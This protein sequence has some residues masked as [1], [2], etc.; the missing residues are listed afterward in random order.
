MA[1]TENT[2]GGRV[3]REAT[4]RVSIVL[5]D[6]CLPGDLIGLSG[7]TWVRADSSNN[8]PP[9]LVAGERCTA[10]G[11]TIM[12]YRTAIVGNFS[13]ASVGDQ[14]YAAGAS[15]TTGQYTATAPA[16]QYRVGKML[17]ATDAEV[18]LN[19]NAATPV[20]V[21]YKTVTGS[22]GA[23]TL[24]AESFTI[25]TESLTTAAGAV[26]TH[27]MTNSVV[28]A[29]DRV[30][31]TVDVGSSAGTPA[32]ASVTPS[33]GQI[34]FKIQNIHASAAFNNAIK[35]NAQVVH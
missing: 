34:V 32:L 6:T 1:F 24:A 26:Y 4:G 17:S 16:V 28:K 35:I 5:T 3:L 25:T 23:S 14:L 33:A 27:T 10:S 7:T 22:A 18:D 12:A 19:L 15:S 29:T 30:L 31:A 21:D 11:G 2:T 13:G 8:I 20:A 9:L